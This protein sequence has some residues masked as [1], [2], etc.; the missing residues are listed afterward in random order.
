MPSIA[1]LI[2]CFNRR[3]H[4]LKCLEMLTA[5]RTEEPR[6][7]QVILVDDGST[8]GTGDAVR[9]A[10]PE[11]RI[12]TGSG[13]LFWNGGMRLAFAEALKSDFDFLLWLNDD[14]ELFPTALD[15]LLRTARNLEEQ[16]ITAIITGSTCDRITGER[17][18]GGELQ[19]KRWFGYRC[20]PVLPLPQHS[21]P[22]DTMNGNC[23][24]IPR[25]IVSALGNLDVAFTHSFGDTDYGFR[26]RSAG[27]SIYIAPGYLGSCSHNTRLGTWRDRS[28]SFRRRWRNLNS[29][30][31]SPFPEWSVYCR[32]HL[33]PL[34][35]LY[36]I[37]P[38]VKTV[39]SSVLH[40]K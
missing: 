36:V 4:T 6:S 39:A 32:R 17:T 3:D 18:Y 26:A 12:L 19:R 13:N 1:V 25:K 22:C 2:A 11:V 28:A 27:F 29:A 14:T 38:Y 40:L 10:F 35:P 20:V 24:L 8:D 31:G 21:Q 16:G 30:K 7:V 34:W 15:V 33:G 5:Q 23:T 9:N 37:S